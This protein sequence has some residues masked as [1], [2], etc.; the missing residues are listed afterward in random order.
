MTA[1]PRYYSYHR[2]RTPNAEMID[3]FHFY[4]P[5]AHIACRFIFPE[6]ISGRNLD[7]LARNE[8]WQQAHVYNHG[9]GHG[10]GCF[11]KCP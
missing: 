8:L 4:V 7:A 6:N 1:L 9:T 10:V 3:N 11:F 2:Y 5:K